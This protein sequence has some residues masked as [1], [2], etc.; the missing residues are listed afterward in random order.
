MKINQFAHTP[1]TFETKL[2]ELSKLRFIK[3]GAQQEDLNLLWKN[4]LLKC[5]PQAKCLAQKHEKLASLAAT[6]TESV[7]EFIEKKTVDLTV[8]YAVAM[9]L[10]QFE[11][12]TEFDID[13]PLKS[14][15]ELG[16]FHADKLEDSTDLI[17]AFYDLLATHGKNGQT[18]LDHLGNLG[19][20]VDFYDLPVSEKPVFFNGKAQPVFDT[21]K[22]IFEVVYVESGLDTDHDGKA[23][24]LKAEIIRPKDTE[25]GLK[26]PA[27]YTASPYNQGTNDA[28]VEAMTHDVN[29]KLT[30]KTPDS[31][32]YDEIK[33]TAKPKTEVKKQTV[34][35]TVKSAN[36]TFPREFSYTLNDYMLARGFAAVYA[37]GIGTMDSDGFRTC[38]SKE[39]T[40]STTAIIEWLA[41]NRKAFIDKTSGIE[42][43]AWWC[44]K[45]VAMTG[46]SYLGTLATAA[47]TTGV[48]GLST[49]IS[50]AA[51]SNW[52]D[53][54]RD[55]G[56]V[57][58]PGG[59][60]GEDADVLAEDCFS[61]RKQ[62]GDFLHVKKDWENHLAEITRGQDRTTGSYNTFWDARNYLKDVQDIKCDVVMVHGLNDW[63]VKPRNVY[64]LYNALQKLPVVSK[65]VLHQGQH[66]YVNNFQSLDFTDMMNLWLSHKLYGL[67]NGAE[68]LLPN[69]LVQD[70]VKES[71]WHAKDAWIDEDADEVVLKATPCGKLKPLSAEKCS[72]DGHD[73]NCHEKELQF[74]DS[75]DQKDF[76]AYVSDIAKWEHDL[77]SEKTPLDSNRIVW[78][79]AAFDK[80]IVLEGA[81]KVSLR[82]KSSRDYGMLSF[83]LIDYGKDKRLGAVPTTLARKAIDCGFHW[84]TDDLMEF[85]L[86]KETPFKLITK[87]HLNLQNRTNLWHADDLSAD[88]YV[89]IDV[90]L[91]PMLHRIKAGHQLGLIVYSTDMGMTV[92]GNEDIRYTLDG[93]KTRLTMNVKNLN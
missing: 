80:D 73:G 21:T 25:E 71:T 14:M 82:V 49:I 93:T 69:V 31:L 84:R 86:A 40:E 56:L 90:V 38:G 33:Y 59:F 62:S 39:E 30:R 16:V 78:K 44:N 51:I 91:Q 57:V 26:V 87:G 72:A 61:R 27:L 8:F 41:G 13:D 37:A 18:L 89:D 70:N 3:A 35:G 83:M 81:P 20:F 48:E 28:T 75:L 79:S 54:Y 7:P 63:N 67:E 92:R 29:V 23:D 50:E 46:K 36:E 64:N 4:L 10:L 60:P 2:E 34:T 19:F 1:A 22:L 9:Q 5:F 47:A 42:I 53:Y 85:K 77:A 11:P 66:I 68:K 52:Y 12:D 24:L 65:L 76:E 88:E 45:H 74:K 43:K 55:G 58:A 32:T 6:K 17:S 15:D